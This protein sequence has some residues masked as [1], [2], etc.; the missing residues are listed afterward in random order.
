MFVNWFIVVFVGKIFKKSDGYVCCYG[1]IIV[2]LFVFMLILNILLSIVIVYVILVVV[3]MRKKVLVKFY[4]GE[5]WLL[6]KNVIILVFRF[7]YWKVFVFGS[8]NVNW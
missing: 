5:I 4:D 8:E 7:F 2:I 6:V 3:N 1:F